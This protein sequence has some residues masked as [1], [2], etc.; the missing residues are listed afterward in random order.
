MIFPWVVHDG[1]SRSQK[2]TFLANELEV[3]TRRLWF[4]QSTEEEEEIWTST[5][6]RCQ[7]LQRPMIG[8]WNRGSLF[9]LLMVNRLRFGETKLSSIPCRCFC[10]FVTLGGLL[11]MWFI[12]SP[13]GGRI[14]RG[15]SSIC[16]SR[17]RYDSPVVPHFP[18]MMIHLYIRHSYLGQQLSDPVLILSAG[19]AQNRGCWTGL[20]GEYKENQY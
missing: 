9:G 3:T 14:P 10:S 4:G 20:L 13:A 5:C 17:R 2:R 11:P 8:N 12:Q 6:Q 16:T 1:H 7:R 19:S 15:R 18:C